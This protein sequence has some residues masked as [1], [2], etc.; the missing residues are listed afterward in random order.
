LGIQDGS[1][2]DPTDAPDEIAERQKDIAP[3][4]AAMRTLDVKYA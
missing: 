1:A 3:L 4:S 2:Y